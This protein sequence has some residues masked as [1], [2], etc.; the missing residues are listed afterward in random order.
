MVDIYMLHIIKYHDSI[1]S[2]ENVWGKVVAS[3][4]KNSLIPQKRCGLL[5]YF[6]SCTS[7][8]VLALLEELSSY[9]WS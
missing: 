3:A 2:R 8:M 6:N 7:S 1:S 5:H 4:M 9:V